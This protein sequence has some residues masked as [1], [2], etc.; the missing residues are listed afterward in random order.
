MSWGFGLEAP[1]N[2]PGRWS[3][4]EPLGFTLGSGFGG[5]GRFAPGRQGTA[6]DSLT[7]KHGGRL[8]WQQASTC[9][10]DLWAWGSGRSGGA[11]AP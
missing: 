5:P 8:R 11:W 4:K 1:E 3:C 2:Y 9:P 10:P 7:T 6:G